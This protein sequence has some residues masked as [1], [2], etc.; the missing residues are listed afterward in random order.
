MCKLYMWVLSTC[1]VHCS[2]TAFVVTAG[3]NQAGK[4]VDGQSLAKLDRET[5]ELSR[6]SRTP[7]NISVLEW[8]HFAFSRQTV[9]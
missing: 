1:T 4:A 5:E 8:V 7:F 3:S 2:L 6:K 9:M